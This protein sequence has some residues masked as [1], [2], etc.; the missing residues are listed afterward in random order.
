MPALPL[1]TLLS[2]LPAAL[3]ANPGQ[4][5]L[6]RLPAEN[7]ARPRL[8]LRAENGFTARFDLSPPRTVRSSLPAWMLALLPLSLIAAAKLRG[9]GP[10]SGPTNRADQ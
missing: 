10:P 5:H 8:L 3:A 1:L 9:Q 6:L 4:T 2:L 7:G